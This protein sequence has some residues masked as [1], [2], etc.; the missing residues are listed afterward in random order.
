MIKLGAW[1]K[2]LEYYG[3]YDFKKGN[4]RKVAKK[5]GHDMTGRKENILKNLKQIHFDTFLPELLFWNFKGV[6]K[7]A[8]GGYQRF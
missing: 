6:N 3:T 7:T 1:Q 4:L 8:G 5:D 2:L